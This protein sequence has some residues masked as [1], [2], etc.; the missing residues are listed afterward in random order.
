MVMHPMPYT[1]N[2][3]VVAAN[4]MPLMCETEGCGSQASSV[5]SGS[6]G[7]PRRSCDLHNPWH[8]TAMPLPLNFTSQSLCQTC[9]QP[10]SLG[11]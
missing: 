4:G 11:G 3:T 5:W 8:N 9:G 10:V 2:V 7:P 1:P 6:Y